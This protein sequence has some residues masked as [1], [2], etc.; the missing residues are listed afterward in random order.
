VE[1]AVVERTRAA[2]QDALGPGFLPL[3][4][5]GQVLPLDRVL[6][7]ALAGEAATPHT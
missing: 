7:E 5:A 6:G 4:T 3:W 1:Q 2:V